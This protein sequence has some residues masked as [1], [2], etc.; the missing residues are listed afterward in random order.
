MLSSTRCGL[1]TVGVI[2]SVTLGL[3]GSLLAQLPP[4]EEIL[5]PQFITADQ[6]AQL[7]PARVLATLRARNK[8]FTEDNLTIR[9]T[10]ERIRKAAKGQHPG[11]IVLSCIDSRVPVEDVF[12]SGIGDL[13]VA[14]VAGNTANP[15]ILGS[16]EYACKVA[17]AKVIVVLG[18]DHC[19]AVKSA[20]D[21][22]ELGNITALLRPIQLALTEVDGFEGEKTS[23]NEDYVEAVC[24]ANIRHVMTC[25]R[26][27]SPILREMEAK[28]EILV[29]GAEY[30]L[31]SGAVDFLNEPR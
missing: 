18:H 4:G 2:M 23:K 10:S 28:G 16:L 13:F 24:H 25:I 7:T 15:E 26:E 8:D 1:A 11:A 17:G 27:K 9:N 29:V 21:H 31:E 12:H 6:Q 19:G 14:R 30:H 20:I 3:I 22:V 5:S